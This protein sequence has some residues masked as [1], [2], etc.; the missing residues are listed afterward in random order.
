MTKARALWVDESFEK[1]MKEG[2][3][4]ACKDVF[5][6]A[7]HKPSFREYTRLVQPIFEGRI[8]DKIFQVQS[9]KKGRRSAH[10][11]IF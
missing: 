8:E 5:S 1:M 6:N 4:K 7:R 9:T 3:E 11:G 2:Y 10:I